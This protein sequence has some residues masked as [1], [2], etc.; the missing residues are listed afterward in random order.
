M[1]EYSED[2]FLAISGIQHFVFCRRQWALIH[3]EQQW[4]ENEKTVQGEIMHEKV[5]NSHLNENRNDVFISRGINVRSRT[6]G[7]TGVCDVVEFHKDEN[8]VSIFGKSG[9]YT[10][11]PVEYK[12]GKPKN[13]LCDVMQIVAQAV[14][15]EQM[16]LCRVDVGYLYYDEI[17]RRQKV[18]ITQ[19]I[20]GQLFDIVKEMHS[21]YERRYTPKVKTSNKCRS[22]SLNE[23]CL[24]KLCYNCNVEK[25]IKGYIGGEK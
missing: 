22:C 16:L 10:P 24:P 8:G 5:H 7:L 4:Q 12:R 6:L 25:Y 1:S 11:V 9:T 13:D 18:E 3:I 20:R 15:L 17:K 2:D 21:Y 23:K 19:E 14:C